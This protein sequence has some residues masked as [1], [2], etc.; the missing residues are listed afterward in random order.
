[1]PRATGAGAASFAAFETGF[2]AARTGRA[3]TKPRAMNERSRCIGDAPLFEVPSSTIATNG[4][5]G[6]ATISQTI[7]NLGVPGRANPYPSSQNVHQTASYERLSKK[8][9]Q[10][11]RK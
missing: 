6:R 11:L 8:K 3:A 2:V 10:L 4:P 7:R 9:S 5:G 1:M